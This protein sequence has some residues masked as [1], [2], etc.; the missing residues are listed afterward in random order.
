MND[1]NVNDFMEFNRVVRVSS[2]GEMTHENGVYGPDEVWVELDS[3]GQMVSLDP[4]DI[5]I[6]GSGWSLLN[7][8]SGQHGYP[9]PIMHPSE[10]LGGGLERHIRSHPGVYVVV[11]VLGMPPGGDGGWDPVGWAVAYREG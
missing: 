3:D 8:F 9:G 11:E 6:E 5:N 10:G 2:E 4:S 7:G 1:I